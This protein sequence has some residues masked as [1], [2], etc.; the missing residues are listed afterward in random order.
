MK[1]ITLACCL[2][3]LTPR[4][5]GGQEAGLASLGIPA[6]AVRLVD[7][8]RCYDPAD[9]HRFEASDGAKVETL[10]GRPARVA[11]ALKFSWMRWSG[12]K[13]G[14]KGR[15]HLLVVTY[16]EDTKRTA[17][18]CWAPGSG[19]T[20]LN[21]IY[22]KHRQVWRALAVPVFTGGGFP[23]DAWSIG[24]L[25]V[26]RGDYVG[27]G[28]PDPNLC[29]MCQAR[30]FWCL[31]GVTGNTLRDVAPTA[32]GEVFVYEVTD[33]KAAF[34]PLRIAHPVRP[35]DERCIG[36]SSQGSRG[37]V[38]FGRQEPT[39]TAGQEEW[40]F[41][42]HMGINLIDAADP[43]RWKMNGQFLEACDARGVKVFIQMTAG[44]GLDNYFARMPK[45][46]RTGLL[47][48]PVRELFEK[49]PALW[50]KTEPL[51]YLAAPA[52][53]YNP[54]DWA[55]PEVAALFRKLMER[56]LLPLVQ[57]K[58]IYAV[59][60][61]PAVG[62]SL[63]S[64][65]LFEK[66]VLGKPI[67]GAIYK[68]KMDWLNSSGEGR[69]FEQWREKKRYEVFA[70]LTSELR[71]IKPDVHFYMPI[72]EYL[73][74]FEHL[75]A[76]TPYP[77]Q[78][79]AGPYAQWAT[80][81]NGI[82]GGLETAF[83][84]R[85][86]HEPPAGHPMLQSR[87][88]MAELA[89]LEEG[90]VA[91][92]RTYESEIEG[93][94]TFGWVLD[95]LN[96]TGPEFRASVLEAMG[97]NPRYL[98]LNSRD[99]SDQ[100]A[101]VRHLASIWRAFPWGRASRL[102]D[103]V[104]SKLP[105][106]APGQVTLLRVRDRFLLLNHGPEPVQAAVAIPIDCV[107]PQLASP[108]LSDAVTGLAVRAAVRAKKLEFSVPLEPFGGATLVLAAPGKLAPESDGT[109]KPPVAAEP[110]E[111]AEP[112]AAERTVAWLQS[113]QNA[114]GGFGY[115]SAAPSHAASGYGCVG[116]LSL[117]KA[118][119]KAPAECA[120]WLLA[121]RNADGGFGYA[122]GTPSDLWYTA[123]A[124]KAMRALD[125]LPKD[126][127]EQTP[128]YIERHMLEP[129]PQRAAL[130]LA[131]GIDA[132]A[133][134]GRQPT[135]RATL[136]A[137]CRKGQRMPPRWEGAFGAYPELPSE[138]M[139]AY[140]LWAL[141]RLGSEPLA[142]D[143]AITYLEGCQRPDGGFGYGW[144]GWRSEVWN[145][146]AAVKA[147]KAVGKLPGDPK[148][149]AAFLRRCRNP[150]GGFGPYVGAPSTPLATLWALEALGGLPT[151]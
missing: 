142:K 143:A 112:I 22:T 62:Q 36:T 94:S 61:A 99:L 19:K 149:C 5:A 113:L 26:G 30:C 146:F 33:E 110:P 123:C 10:L 82:L 53:G 51:S 131:W 151:P 63:Q 107:A 104:E 65:Q 38:P 93:G 129:T 17:V 103:C 27:E 135:D 89:R 64:L 23:K 95:N 97:H 39:M 2:A 121:C 81:A 73:R 4:L 57:H 70:Q 14:Q 24:F 6:G 98:M 139:T 12:L 115:R 68:A 58:S 138:R 69:R 109:V 111:A 116:A 59:K 114:D 75:G 34:P 71:K 40:F 136:V 66:E 101:N 1:T 46:Q 144:P 137:A 37:Q 130:Y 44:L 117:L 48:S 124:L 18:I 96:M 132:L 60:F 67:P 16:P 15:L 87:S 7:H 119:P 21:T 147:L 92:V 31:S 134:L 3:L 29:E 20:Y 91:A 50:D 52:L 85:Y 148:A 127:I 41:L 86:S 128:A 45:A 106:G 90:W 32:L 77:C 55:N 122:P 102:S 105:G 84:T 13:L 140:S 72:R 8:V 108:Q 56:N 11:G 28:K 83:Y 9:P 49:D 79:E 35:E 125:A 126:K 145:T 78:A 47:P 54:W 74:T 43:Q 80:G 150:D 88:V 76:T 100:L 133:V 141:S 118:K 42:D 25:S 120:A